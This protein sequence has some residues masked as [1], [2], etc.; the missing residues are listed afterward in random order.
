MQR[1]LRNNLESLNEHKC[2]E[3]VALHIEKMPKYPRTGT[4][5]SL[6]EMFFYNTSD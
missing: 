4:H 6:V 3:I 5:G 2:G 1:F